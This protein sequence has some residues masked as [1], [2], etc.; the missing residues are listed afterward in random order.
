MQCCRRR[1]SRI[2]Q[3]IAISENVSIDNSVMSN[4][5]FP[6]SDTFIRIQV[7]LCVGG[8]WE[9]VHS[10]QCIWSFSDEETP[11]GYRMSASRRYPTLR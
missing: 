1:V 10:E 11:L 8:A 7:Q 3:R 6:I 2:S 4:I 9:K 5:V